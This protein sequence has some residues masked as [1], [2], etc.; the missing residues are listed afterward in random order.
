MREK[1]ILRTVDTQDLE[2]EL[3]G[4]SVATPYKVEM[5]GK[6]EKERA[7]EEGRLGEINRAGDNIPGG[8][9]TV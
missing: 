2:K 4:L 7:L 3:K 5:V 8:W 1:G 6:E 9:E